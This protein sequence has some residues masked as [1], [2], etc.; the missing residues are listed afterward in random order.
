MQ[1]PRLGATCRRCREHDVL[2]SVPGRRHTQ[3]DGQACVATSGPG[4]APHA[5]GW[6]RGAHGVRVTGLAGG[7]RARARPSDNNLVPLTVLDCKGI[8]ATRRERIDAAV[9]AGGK[10]LHGTHQA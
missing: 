5:R 7:N 4:I 2:A 10:Q 8:P 6:A 1:S 9:T 3:G